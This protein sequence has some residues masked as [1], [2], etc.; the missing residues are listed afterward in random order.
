MDR[1]LRRDA[2]DAMP[3][4]AGHRVEYLF[5]VDRTATREEGALVVR[6]LARTRRADGTWDRPTAAA[7]GP[8]EALAAAPTDRRLLASLLGATARESD[9]A[10]QPRPD[11]GL[12]FILPGALA[13]EW[14]PLAARAGRLILRD[15][16][17]STSIRPLQWDD[18]P[19]WRFTVEA[20]PED[21]PE[22]HWVSGVLTRREDRLKVTDP[23]LLLE[24]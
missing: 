4:G 21:D 7:A 13:L 24:V 10:D 1:Q 9:Q 14:V 17:E 12:R 23:V 6:L 3:P 16:P 5:A 2:E 22:G 15:G 11:S 19:V 8:H 20:L 18:G